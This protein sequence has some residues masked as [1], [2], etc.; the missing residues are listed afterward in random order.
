MDK[1][2]NMTTPG[3]KN[4][5]EDVQRTQKKIVNYEDKIKELEAKLFNK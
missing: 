1:K 4:M 2:H 3:K 5:K